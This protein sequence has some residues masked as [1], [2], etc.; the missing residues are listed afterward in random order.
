MNGG[1]QRCY[2]AGFTLLELTLA[3]AVLILVLGGTAHTL[4]SFYGALDIQHQRCAAVQNCRSVLSDMRTVRDA[5]PGNFPNA[6]VVQWPDASPVV[7]AGT[8]PNEVITVT[9]VNPAANP[10]EVNVTSR[11]MDSVGRGV[12]LSMTTLLT[13]R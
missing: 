13:D 8:L 6:I 5:N 9:Y 10:L 12:S 2:K 4:V 7:G 1:M 3:M 11:W